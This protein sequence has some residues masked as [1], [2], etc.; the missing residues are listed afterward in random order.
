MTWPTAV[1]EIRNALNDTPVSK[2]SWRKKVLGIT[3]GVN[4]AFK[5]FEFRR[6]S[7]L[8]GAV[9]PIGVM[10]NDVAAVVDSEDLISGEFTL[11]VA[12]LEGDRVECTYYHQWFLDNELSMFLTTAA[13]YLGYT[14]F[15]TVEPGLR[16]ALLCY[17]KS[18]AYMELAVRFARMLSEQYM[19]EDL[20]Q[21]SCKIAIDS[22][23]RLADQS[24]KYAESLI[25]NYYTRQGR[26]LQP[27]FAT[28][29][30]HVRDVKSD[31]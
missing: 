26:S 10:V 6:V 22:Y 9:Y 28:I 7:V 3:D 4:K 27:L 11:H 16:P 19:M 1:A 14:D 18:E 20:P 31:K 21:K 15:D 8:V 17:A 29:G 25:K 2:L 24:K 5:T 23:S 13:Q 30:G 12:P